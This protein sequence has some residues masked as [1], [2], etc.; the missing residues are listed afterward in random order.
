MQ[1]ATAIIFLLLIVTAPWISRKWGVKGELIWG[2]I[3]MAFLV[4]V[5]LVLN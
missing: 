5:I 2:M 4:T 1:T 3:A